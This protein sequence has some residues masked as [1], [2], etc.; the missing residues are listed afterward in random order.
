MTAIFG[1]AS[2]DEALE[3]AQDLV[4]DAW[5]AKTARQRI[6]LAKKALAISPLCA[7]AHV[8]LAEHA[9]PNSE[10]QLAFYK[11]GLQAGERA[12]GEAALEEDVGYFWGLL[13]TRPYMRARFGLAQVL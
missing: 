13:E 2:G 3:R 11:L 4:Y 8:L 12:L 7:D 10:Q 1:A 5:E 6:A 9:T